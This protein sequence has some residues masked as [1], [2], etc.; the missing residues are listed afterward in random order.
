ML[1]DKIVQLKNESKIDRE[2]FENSVK[3]LEQEK[4][5]ADSKKMTLK[6]EVEN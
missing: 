2:K 3:I 5:V 1:K 6:F 4:N